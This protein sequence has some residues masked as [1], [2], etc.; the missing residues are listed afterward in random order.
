MQCQ[1]LEKSFSPKAVSHFNHLVIQTTTKLS[2]HLFAEFAVFP[3]IDSFLGNIVGARST[4]M[5][6]LPRWGWQATS[7]N[8]AFLS[9]PV[10]YS[11]IFLSVTYRFVPSALDPFKRLKNKGTFAANRTFIKTRW[12]QHGQHSFAVGNHTRF[13]NYVVEA[14][15]LRI[16]PV[17]QGDGIWSIHDSWTLLLFS[18]DNGHTVSLSVWKTCDWNIQHPHVQ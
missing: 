4:T 14:S 7:Y 12:I 3:T 8:L 18:N 16:N 5:A 15:G 9:R 11:D 1:E 2:F 13:A 6:M 17:D 10:K